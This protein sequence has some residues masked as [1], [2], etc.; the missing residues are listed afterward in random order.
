MEG[1]VCLNHECEAKKSTKMMTNYF[2]FKKKDFSSYFALVTKI[3][4]LSS[5]IFDVEQFLNIL[6]SDSISLLDIYNRK[7]GKIKILF[8]QIPICT[9]GI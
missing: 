6:T 1:Q 4:N 3:L 2:T 8:Q 7:S 5:R 9:K